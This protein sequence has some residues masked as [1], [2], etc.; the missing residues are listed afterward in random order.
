MKLQCH[1]LLI[2]SKEK[3]DACTNIRSNSKLARMRI[4]ITTERTL[5]MPKIFPQPLYSIQLSPCHAK[6]FP[7]LAITTLALLHR[8]HACSALNSKDQRL[9][10][11]MCRLTVYYAHTY[12][13]HNLLYRNHNN[14][15]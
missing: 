7:A 8:F 15:I 3:N 13:N 12:S 4:I 6:S 11:Q 1:R 5:R 2:K 10:S 14:I 9:T